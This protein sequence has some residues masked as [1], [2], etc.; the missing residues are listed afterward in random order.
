MAINPDEYELVK[1][2][3]LFSC[4]G[5][6]FDNSDECLYNCDTDMIWRKKSPLTDKAHH[7]NLFQTVLRMLKA[8]EF[9]ADEIEQFRDAVK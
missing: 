6:A 4:H 8:G 7:D 9:S 1:G 3:Y 2:E 5:C